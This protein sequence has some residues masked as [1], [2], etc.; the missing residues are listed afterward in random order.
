M[1]IKTPADVN[2]S[3]P[4]HQYRTYSY[5]HVLIACTNST[6]VQESFGNIPFDQLL[7]TDQAIGNV[8]ARATPRLI[9]NNPQNPYVVLLNTQ[10]DSEF[11]VKSLTFKV[12]PQ[13]APQAPSDQKQNFKYASMAFMNEGSMVIEE[14]FGVRFG[15]L[16]SQT[17]L[18]LKCAPERLVFVIKT[19]FFGF[20]DEGVSVVQYIKPYSVCIWE[21]QATFTAAGGRYEIQ[22]MPYDNGFAHR[23]GI[24]M[25]GSAV[26]FQ[27]GPTIGETMA[28]F[29]QIL[30]KD[31]EKLHETDNTLQQIS[32]KIIVDDAYLTY[33]IDK[34]VPANSK[35]KTEIQI[36][37]SLN[38]SISEIIQKIMVSSPQVQNELAQPAQTP[39][40]SEANPRTDRFVFKIWSQV[41]NTRTEFEVTYRVQRQ[42]IIVMPVPTQQDKEKDPTILI[43]LHKDATTKFIADAK[44]AN[45]YLE[46]DYI[47]SGKN[48]DILD[49]EMKMNLFT[50]YA[51]YYAERMRIDAPGQI[52]NRTEPGFVTTGNTNSMST[53]TPDISKGLQLS[54]L[55]P[56]YLNLG[57]NNIKE[58]HKFNDF[59]SRSVMIGTGLSYINM[60]IAGDP[61]LYAGF[62]QQPFDEAGKVIDPS[63]LAGKPDQVMSNWGRLPTLIKVNIF[64]PNPPTAVSQ[65]Q[66]V[67]SAFAAPFYHDGLYWV[68]SI[69]NMFTDDGKFTQH[70]E[71]LSIPPDN[72]IANISQIGTGTASATNANTVAEATAGSTPAAIKKGQQE[73]LAAQYSPDQ[74]KCLALA[75]Q[76][77]QRN[78]M[79]P[80]ILQGILLADSNACDPQYMDKAV[81]A[82]GQPTINGATYLSTQ[83]VLNFLKDDPNTVAAISKKSGIQATRSQNSIG[84]LLLNDEDFNLDMCAKIWLQDRAYV[85]MVYAQRTNQGRA[86][87]AVIPDDKKDINAQATLAHWNMTNTSSFFSFAGT[88]SADVGF[89]T[90]AGAPAPNEHK[91]LKDIAANQSSIEAFNA[92]FLPKIIPSNP[93]AVASH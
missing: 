16:I 24:S 15:D 78:G 90:V 91:Y 62:L 27:C 45:N 3:N 20:T 76:V 50:V 14:P 38:D 10:V 29:Q 30:N 2:S 1:A 64:M 60:T 12:I 18:N 55:P 53:S 9:N 36:V 51:S 77:A 40:N 79:P 63:K 58:F 43:Q 8:S 21:I 31:Q 4:L 59:L 26:K 89:N 80:Q 75:F 57:V 5:H 81:A 65:D 25:V 19:A 66:T 23:K 69:D 88:A 61:R 71:L 87:P 73:S 34:T 13:A 70:L 28:R 35:N 37:G 83:R 32:Y 47:Y 92:T 44:A 49:F 68:A 17:A 93:N 52:K 74:Q 84:Y 22:F 7:P 67:E 48:V 46:Y 72:N 85:Q 11:L 6:L 41:K 33:T 56:R 82:K 42:K 86:A 54:P 39:E